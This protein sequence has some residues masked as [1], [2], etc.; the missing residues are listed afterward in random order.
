VLNK[1]QKQ[2]LD[3]NPAT[4][5]QLAETVPH[6]IDRQPVYGQEYLSAFHKKVMAGTTTN[7]VFSGDSTTAGDGTTSPYRIHEIFKTLCDNS[8]ITV[9]TVNKGHSGAWTTTWANTYVTDD[10]ASNPDLLVIRWGLNDARTDLNI[11]N[12]E[13]ALRNGLT[14]IRASRALNS[15][16][17]VLMSPNNV[18]S[19]DY[20]EKSPNWGK[21]INAMLRKVARDFKCCFIDTFAIW[22]DAANGQDWM[23]S[24]LVHPLNVA[25]VW[26][27]SKIF[28]VVFPS[29]Y[30]KKTTAEFLNAASGTQN[31]DV[32]STPSLYTNGITIYQTLDNKFPV[33]GNAITFK[34]KTDTVLQIVTDKTNGKISIRVG[35]LGSDTWG[36]WIT[37]RSIS[38]VANPTLQNSWVNFGGN[39]DPV[40]YYID[41]NNIVHLQ[42]LIKEGVKTQDITLFTLP[43]GFIPTKDKYLPAVS[44]S[45]VGVYST[46]CIHI[47]TTGQVKLYSGD[48][49][50]LSL[51]GVSFRV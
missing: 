15:L 46:A 49:G 35:F 30:I 39:T 42:G 40:G 13:T 8:G 17:I 25:N 11:T 16:S 28:D 22:N 5:E 12:Y 1:I 32:I 31:L 26:I 2:M 9:T 44:A 3:F 47:T 27:S 50:W 6:N 18:N 41:S 20:P 51:E 38:S 10:L 36:E 24:Y 48:N 4:A 14:T 29:Y 19:V 37:L 43:A 33:D 23:D 7:V 21:K 34:S 45:S